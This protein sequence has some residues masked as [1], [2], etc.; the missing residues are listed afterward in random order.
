MNALLR[1]VRDGLDGQPETTD[2]EVQVEELTVGSASRATLQ[3]IG[4]DLRPEHAVLRLRNGRLWLTASGPAIEVNGSA[5]ESAPLATD[6]L[7]VMGGHRIRVLDPPSGFDAALEVRLDPDVNPSDFETAF[8]TALGRTRLSK[9]A[10]AWLLLGMV[11]ALGMGLPLTN[12]LLRHTGGHPPAWLP[13]DAVWSTGPLIPTHELASHGQCSVC[14]A[15]LFERVTDKSC[16]KCHDHE[17]D[18][19]RLDGEQHAAAEPTPRCAGCHRE[20]YADTM[21]FVPRA[22]SLCTDCHRQPKALTGRRPIA[23]VTS[24]AKDRHPEFILKL[25]RPEPGSGASAG[26][27]TWRDALVPIG[28]AQEQSN[29]SFSHVQHL[30]PAKVT[31]VGGDAPLG[32]ADCH[33]LSVDGAHFQPITMLGKCLSCHSLEFARGRQLPHGQTA[34]AVTILEDF[35]VRNFSG[36]P[37]PEPQRVR[38]LPDRGA[39]PPACT[40]KPY[41]CG[42]VRAR[43]EV[44][45]QFKVRGCAGCHTVEDTGAASLADRFRVAPVRLATDYF[46]SVRFYHRDHVVQRELTGDRACL[47]CHHADRSQRSS[48][49]LIPPIAKCLECHAS[50]ATADKVALRCTSCHAYHPVPAGLPALEGPS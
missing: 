24:F 31:R 6:D 32:C 4:R 27:V 30:D 16:R 7:I 19:V 34:E 23:G 41:D 36:P 13:G 1:Y 26:G 15:T 44:E 14:H 10:P 35:Y 43:F 21:H 9:R 33:T 5:V 22:D 2:V 47:S 8:T 37:L 49:V 48:D 46:H 17:Q 42:M 3:L 25:L 28:S 38:R 11:L 40:G 50:Q 12:V 39:P 18:H 45:N 20:H 29:L